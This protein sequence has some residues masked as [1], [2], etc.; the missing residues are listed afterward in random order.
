VISEG[1][2]LSRAETAEFLTERGYKTA[3]ATLAK[4]AV[5]GG[6]PPFISWGRK[7]LYDP[8]GIARMGATPLHWASALYFRPR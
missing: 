7:P 3:P 2:Y 1:R 8:A 5:I 6:G 4:L